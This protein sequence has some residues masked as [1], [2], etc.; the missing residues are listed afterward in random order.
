VVLHGKVRTIQHQF[1]R[2]VLRP[3][4]V[5]DG[6]ELRLRRNERQLLIQFVRVV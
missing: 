4:I 1:W 2:L 5:R 6:L 3:L